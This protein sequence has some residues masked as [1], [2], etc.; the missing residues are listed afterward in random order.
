MAKNMKNYIQVKKLVKNYGEFCAVDNLS[1][2]VEEGEIFGLLGPNGAGKSTTINVLSTLTNYQKGDV[3]INGLD[4]NK[5]AKEIK[6]LIGLVPQDIAIYNHLTA[7]ENVAFFASCYGLKG[8]E[9]RKAVEEALEFV[10]LSDKAKLTPK[11][12]SGGM[13]R[14]LNIACGIAHR[15]K[16]IIM[17]EPTVGVDAQSRDYIL[18]SI[19]KLRRKG[20]TVIYTSHYMNEVEEICDRI[21]IVDRGKMVACGTKNQLI[22]LTTESKTFQIKFKTEDSF[23]SDEFIKETM[24]L[25]TIKRVVINENI[26]K[27]ETGLEFSDISWLFAYLKEK[28]I[29][30]IAIQT[31]VPDLDTVFIALTGREMR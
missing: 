4:L 30:I 19:K 29:E 10:G 25:P 13:K 11:K 16:L 9:L 5:K 26:M 27:I 24:K 6:A 12:M 3:I 1:F 20:V 15:P 28:N 14:R 21:A 17:D 31:L 22:E 2:E 23:H 8:E 7:Y 18:N